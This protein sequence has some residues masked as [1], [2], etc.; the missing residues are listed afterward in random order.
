MIC[1]TCG[2]K[3]IETGRIDYEEC[4][5]IDFSCNEHGLQLIKSVSKRVYMRCGSYIDK[6]F[7][8]TEKDLEE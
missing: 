1:K 6:N 5:N 3:L 8:L 4:I 7:K 2:K